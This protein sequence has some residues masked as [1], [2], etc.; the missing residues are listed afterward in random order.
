VAE[1]GSVTARALLDRW[2]T[3]A[4]EFWVLRAVPP[5]ATMPALEAVAAG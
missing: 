3:A 1:T 2:A 5:A 4:K